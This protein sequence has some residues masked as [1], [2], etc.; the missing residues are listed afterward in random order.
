MLASLGQDQLGMYQLFTNVVAYLILI[1]GGVGSATLFSLYKPVET[2]NLEEERIIVRTSKYLFNIICGL[3]FVLGLI[4]TLTITMFIKSNPFDEHYVQLCFFLYMLSQVN[5][6][7]TVTERTVFDAHQLK[8]IPN[9]IYQ[10]V[11]IVKA[12]VEIAIVL[13]GGNLLSIIISLLIISVLSNATM[14]L[15]YYRQFGK[16]NLSGKKDFK[17]LKNV[18]HLFVNTLA[19][20]VSNNIDILILSKFIGSAGVV[21]YSSYNF[22]T[23]SLKN[24]VEK[25]T[26]SV[27]SSVGTLIVEDK[28][29]AHK[30]FNELA[31][32]TLFMAMVI[33]PPLAFAINPFIQII[34][35]GGVET[36]LVLATLFTALFYYELVSVPLKTYTL[37]S[38]LFK[39]IKNYLIAQSII[40]LLLSLILVNF[41]G[42]KGVLVATLISYVI[43]DFIPKTSIIHKHIFEESWSNFIKSE[44]IG[45]LF[46]AVSIYFVL[47]LNIKVHNLMQW[48]SYSIVAFTINIIIVF[49]LFKLTGNRG[50]LNRFIESLR[51]N[52]EN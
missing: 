13:L 15:F 20:L 38:G 31:I 46:T 29:K 42:I 8:Y 14:K 28:K 40:N 3:I 33:S 35:S 50:F 19:N 16:I 52:N 27:M 25:I 49:A 23:S 43:A 4:L 11:N 12:I 9:L 10:S 18:K 32:L 2:K 5:Y 17:L 7:F 24:F 39:E 1:E 45:L 26:G 22:I 21:V 41:M 44:I 30:V 34:Y 6:Y 47:S 51:R 37:S 48:L 36:S